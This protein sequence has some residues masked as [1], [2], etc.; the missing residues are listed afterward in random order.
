MNELKG[1]TIYTMKINSDLKDLEIVQQVKQAS[2]KLCKQ[3]GPEGKKR[4]Q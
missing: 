4:L 3:V 2:L 1:K